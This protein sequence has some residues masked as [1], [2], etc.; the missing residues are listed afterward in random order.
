MILLLCGGAVLYG[1]LRAEIEPRYLTEHWLGA[2][3]QVQGEV[4][5]VYPN[6]RGAS[7]YLSIYQVSRDGETLHCMIRARWNE[8]KNAPVPSTGDMVKLT[9]VLGLPVP[10]ASK[11]TATGVTV[12]QASKSMSPGAKSTVTPSAKSTNIPFQAPTYTLTGRLAAVRTGKQGFWIF[13]RSRWLDFGTQTSNVTPDHQKLAASIVFGADDGLSAGIKQAFLGAGL[14]HV[15]AASGA[16]ILLLEV[17]LEH[18]LY[19]LWRRVRL[20]FWGWCL[21]LIACI[22]SFAGMCG[23]QPSIVR[24]ALMSSYRQLGF[25]VGRKASISMSLAVAAAVITFAQPYTMLSPSAWLS[26]VA[27]AAM[28]QQLFSGQRRFQHKAGQK[29]VSGPVTRG[30]TTFPRAASALWRFTKRRAATVWGIV[31]M[32]VRVEMWAAPLVLVLFGQVTPYSIVAN[33]ICEPLVGLV[34]PVSIAWLSLC[35]AVQWVP[36]LG[37]LETG[38]G[39]VE[40][41]LVA[42]LSFVVTGVSSWPGA[43]WTITGLPVWCIILY[44]LLLTVGRYFLFKWLKLRSYV[45]VS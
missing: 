34:L 39:Y 10:Y 28:T 41:H 22:W 18:T 14:L 36:V 20:P 1:A 29:A 38:A 15:L 4:I 32:T 31:L 2:S 37:I 3:V 16:N 8:G 25:A 35:A 42:T 33:V 9:G 27:T 17:T 30:V 13:V 40:E 5:G 43:L 6:T 12:N 44:Y 45:H 19:P 11:P 26:F 7:V 24:A 21:F 23:F